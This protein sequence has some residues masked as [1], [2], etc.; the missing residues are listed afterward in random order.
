MA[1]PL[2]SSARVLR[3]GSPLSLEAIRQVAPAVFAAEPH[4]SRG[5]RYAYVPTSDPLTALMDNGWG[6]YEASQQRS[7]V[8]GK[9]PYTKHM[10]RM[11]KLGDFGT[12]AT[13]VYEKDEGVPE[14]ILINAHDGTAA[15]HLMAGFF[16]FVCSNGLMVGKHMGGFKVRHTVGP[17][18]SLEV[19]KAGE[20]TVTQKFPIMVEQ[21]GAMKHRLLTDTQQLMLAD[22]ALNLRYGSSVAPFHA[23]ELLTARRDADAGDSVWRVMNRVQENIIDGGWETRS[24]MFGRRSAVRPVERVTAVAQ[25]NG[26]IWDAA[27]ALVA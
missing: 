15:Y 2:I 3:T 9:D 19:L 10:L 8:Q 7:R 23:Q 25:I 13:E 20:E 14:V 4:E 5:P 16:R 24:Q 27:L 17:Q 22:V 11:R 6:V 26:G 1:R 21:I 18:T 12:S